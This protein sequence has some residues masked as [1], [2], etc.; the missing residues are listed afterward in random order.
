MNGGVRWMPG[1]LRAVMCSGK[2]PYK[3]GVLAGKAKDGLKRK[4]RG[5]GLADELNVYRC[6]YCEFWHIGRR[7]RKGKG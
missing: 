4:R 3:S 5:N 2:T 6:E 7:P 1:E